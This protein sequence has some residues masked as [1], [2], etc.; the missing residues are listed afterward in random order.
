M[1]NPSPFLLPISL[2]DGLF[3]RALS[4]ILRRIIPC[5]GISP[6][7]HHYP[8]HPGATGCSGRR[9]RRGRARTTRR[10]VAVG[11]LRPGRTGAG[12]PAQQAGQGVSQ[13][14]YLAGLPGRDRGA[15]LRGG[16]GQLHCRAAT[17]TGVLIG[18]QNGQERG[19]LSGCAISLILGKTETVRLFNANG[20]DDRGLASGDLPKRPP[21]SSCAC[22]GRWLRGCLQSIRRAR[23]AGSKRKPRV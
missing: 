10:L 8:S 9:A 6:Y 21:S 5:L 20:V 19:R 22:D 14:R 1:V 18:L 7:G 23:L 13:T 4:P 16:C 11:A 2:Q 15:P 17:T 3:C 12:R